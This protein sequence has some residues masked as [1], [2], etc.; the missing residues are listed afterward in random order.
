LRV[1][2][3]FKIRRLGVF[4]GYESVDFLLYLVAEVMVISTR[5]AATLAHY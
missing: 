1:R 4:S 3:Y 2:I 5:K